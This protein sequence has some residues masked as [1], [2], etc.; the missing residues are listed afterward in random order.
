MGWLASISVPAVLVGFVALERWRPLRKQVEPSLGREARN[1]AMAAI[2][3]LSV[4]L[5]QTPLVLPLTTIVELRRIG[6]LKL[7]SMPA[8]GETLLAVL[9]MDY[10]QYLWHVAAHKSDFL[11]RFHAPHHVDLDLSTTTGVR[12][13][14]GE[15]LLSMPFRAAQIV[16]FGVSP[17][18]F[19]I[20]Q[21]LTTV[22]ILFHHSNL[23]LPLVVERWL[24][25]LIVTP[26]MHG[27]HHSAV[28]AETDSNWSTIF[29]FYDRLHRTLRLDVP[30]EEIV[31]G[32]PAYRRSDEVTLGN[33][34]SLP[35]GRH[36]H[37][38]TR[39]GQKEPERAPSG[40]RKTDLAP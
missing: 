5:V 22:Q 23:R 3:G 2:A 6:L 14:F 25:L 30:Q 12:F 21:T 24:S 9:L 4:A 19:A 39:P 11:W 15:M 40:R 31:I 33:S 17:T 18:A 36:F 16:A 37:R 7:A 10:T 1:L 38:W 26:R 13:H 27:I 8:A 29:S 35:F 32:V 28:R 34:L 20:W